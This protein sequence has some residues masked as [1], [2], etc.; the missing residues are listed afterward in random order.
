MEGSPGDAGYWIMR[1][2]AASQGLLNM[3]RFEKGTALAV[4]A[5]ALELNAGFS[6]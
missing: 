2:R 5:V 4:A 3:W 1:S 6:A